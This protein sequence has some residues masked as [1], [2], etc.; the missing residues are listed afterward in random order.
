M[1]EETLEFLSSRIGFDANRLQF[2]LDYYRHLISLNDYVQNRW[3]EPFQLT[4]AAVAVGISPS[5]LSHLFLEKTGISFT[6]WTRYER[7]RRAAAL[8]IS[9]E[10]SIDEVAYSVGY[11][12]PKTFQRSFTKAIGM[13]PSK[14]RKIAEAQI[15]SQT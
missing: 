7:V 1:L 15:T 2:A 3:H 12:N 14:Y 5:R 11:K 10:K 6:V 4:E 9:N 8:L 13:T